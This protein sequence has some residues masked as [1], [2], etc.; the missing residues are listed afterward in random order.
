[1]HQ[2]SFI[3]ASC[4][5][6]LLCFLVYSFHQIFLKWLLFCHIIFSPLF[7][8]DSNYMFTRPLEVVLQ[9]GDALLFKNKSFFSQLF[10]LYGFCCYI[11][12][13]TNFFLKYLPSVN[14]LQGIFYLIHCIFFCR[15]LICV[16]LYLL[17]H[18]LTF[19]PCG[20]QL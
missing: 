18:Y 20:T 14:F 19:L 3:G 2:C 15:S 1:M 5:W 17:H 8:G 13:V 6:C 11:F 7:F 4:A 10:I 12:K 9:L 16:F